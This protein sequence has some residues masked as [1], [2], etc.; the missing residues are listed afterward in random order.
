M[1][2]ITVLFTALITTLGITGWSPVYADASGMQQ[3]NL[4]RQG[5]SEAS[6]LEV[7]MAR[8]TIPAD[9]TLPRHW[10]PGE[11]FAYLIEGSLVL[12]QDGKTDTPVTAGSAVHVPLNQIHTATAGPAGATI[13]VFRVHKKGEPDRILVD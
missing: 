2:R 6:D 1:I 3:T 5:L 10:H 8:V 13:L 4:L 12:W 7:V 9:T 11:E